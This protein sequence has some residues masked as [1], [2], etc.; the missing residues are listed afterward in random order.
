V[1]AIPTRLPRLAAKLLPMPRR[2][3]V[4]IATRGNY[5]KAKSILRAIID[6]PELELQ[7]VVTGGI[8]LPELED[9]RANIRADGFPIAEFVPFR[10]DGDS[11]EIMALSA[12][13]A[14]LEFS[15]TLTRLDP[16]VVFIIADRFEALS[17]AHA[18]ICMNKIIA[19]LEGGEVSGS[20]D[21]RIR[22]AITKL[23]HIHFP[24]NTDA[25]RRIE[26][27]GEIATS[28]FPVGSPSLDLL[29]A[30]DVDDSGPLFDW[31]ANLPHQGVSI[32]FD[33][34]Y[35]LVSQHPVVTEYVCADEQLL[36]TAAAV[37][38]LG[39]SV[40]WI[41]PNMDA[42]QTS[43]RR[44]VEALRRSGVPVFCSSGVSMEIYA[45]L[46]R[47]AKVMIG[48]SSS[49]IREAEY[50]GVPV[51]NVGSRQNGRQR[52]RNV[53]DVGYVAEDIENAARLQMQHGRFASEYVYGDGRAGSKIAEMLSSHKFELDKVI[54]Y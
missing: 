29:T 16:D 52:G 26:R 46:M 37:S 20:I 35:I 19:H 2:I 18:A 8:M 22:H 17:F 45:R 53:V 49:G 27:M 50:L 24:S 7:L 31:Q 13:L 41:L 32:D 54:C 15:R 11:L 23:A 1:A 14:T 39:K 21:E 28:I 48:N 40:V 36:T 12:A 25:A 51:V 4:P 33:M 9:F 42:G 3:C 5:G 10:L 47:K 30:I 6:R 44:G 43:G 34:D 38:R